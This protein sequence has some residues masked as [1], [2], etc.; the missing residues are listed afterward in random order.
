MAQEGFR[1]EIQNNKEESVAVRKKSEYW[2]GKQ[3]IEKKK[4]TCF[5]CWLDTSWYP[6]AMFIS[7]RTGERSGSKLILGKI[8]P[9]DCATNLV[10]R[11]T[12]EWW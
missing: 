11:I 6:K 3:D 4:V 5:R 12:G 8:A 1:G 9:R 7:S 10:E 2:A